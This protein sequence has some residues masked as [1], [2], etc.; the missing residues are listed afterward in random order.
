VTQAATHA[1]VPRACTV[2]NVQKQLA[3]EQSNMP[4]CKV[5]VTPDHM[6]KVNKKKK[7]DVNRAL[8]VAKKHHKDVAAAPAEMA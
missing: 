3:L 8:S 7:A 5:L 4:T 2:H 1:A 6:D